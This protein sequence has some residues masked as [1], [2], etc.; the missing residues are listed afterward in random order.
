M[1]SEYASLGLDVADARNFLTGRTPLR[2][3]SDPTLTLPP[4]VPG[5]AGITDADFDG[6]AAELGCESAAVKAVAAVEGGS[7]GCFAA[8]GRPIIR[9]ELHVFNQRTHGKYSKTHPYF[10]TGYGA[11]KRAHTRLQADEWSMMYGAMMMRG[12]RD[13]ALASASW[14]AFQIMGFNHKAAGYATATD[15][16]QGMCRS[17]GH[18]LGAFLKFAKGK[19]ATRYLKAKD[20]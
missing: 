11:G 19:G 3:T 18:Q 15:L 7:L 16:A 14:G 8:D 12:Q 2:I 20:W 5:Q 17:A 1:S 13:N 4:G 10:A 6:A 9:Y